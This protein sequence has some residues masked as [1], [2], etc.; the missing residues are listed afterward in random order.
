MTTQMKLLNGLSE[1]S[2]SDLFIVDN[3]DDE[4]KV[5]RY[6]HDWCQL[7]KGFDIASGYFEIASLLA[8]DGEW[9][10]VDH[11]RLLMGNEVSWRT[12]RAFEKA[13]QVLHQRLDDSIETEKEKN[14]FLSGVPAI[15]EAL[16]A[17]KIECR[18]YRKD[19][20]HAKAYLTHGRVDVVGS[21]ALVGSSNFT[22]PGLTEN[23][24]L[25]VQI[26]GTPVAALQKWY[27]RHWEEAEDVTPEILR[28]VERHTQKFLPFE[29]YA[30]SLQELFHGYEESET[31][32][33]RTKSKVY[34]VLA[35]YQKEG[36]HALLK[37]ANKYGGAFLCDG[38]G[39][40][41]T[42]IGMMLIERLVIYERKRVLLLI[43]KAANEPVWQKE[44][45][46]YLPELLEG[47]F[48]SFQMYNHT[49][50]S[51]DKMRD[52][53][54]R[55]QIQADVIIIDEAHHFRNTG[56]Q[57]DEETW[58]E[59][60][61]YW[62]LFDVAGE[63]QVFHL[64]ATPINNSLLDFQH[65]IEL[66]S[67]RRSDYF[68]AAPLGIHSLAGHIRT[69]E[70][71]LEKV[72]RERSEDD[73]TS[74]LNL[75]EAADVL[76]TDALFRELVVQRSRK[77]VK[78]STETAEDDK[79]LFP[80][81]RKPKVAHYSVKQ[82]Y[83]KLLDMV[84]AAFS[85]QE[86]LFKLSIYYPYAF[87]TG[88]DPEVIPAFERGRRMQ[89]VSLVRTGF[90]KRFE[91]SAEAF[92]ASCWNLMR[93][94]LVWVEVHAETEL[95]RDRVEQWKR[96]NA[97]LINYKPQ[98]ELWSDDEDED[99]VSPE[100]LE[101]VDELSRDEFDLEKIILNTF[102]DLDQIAMFLKELEAFTPKQ[103][104]KLQALIK[105]L[106]TD[107]VLKKHKVL[108]FTEY[109]TTARYLKEQLD[110]AGLKGVAEIDSATKVNRFDLIRR[111]APYYNGSSSGA[112][113][114]QGKEEI[115]VLISTD[116]LAEGLN[117]QDA[118]RLINYEL[119]WNPV[120]LMQRIGRVDRRLNPDI[121]QKIIAAHPEQS[122]LR[123]TV[124][125][126][127]FLPPDELDELLRL[128]RRVAHKTLRISKTLGIEGKRLLREDDDY[129]DLRNFTEQYEG[130]LTPI[131]EMHLEYQQ[132]LKDHS[133][134]E[135]RLNGFPKKIF[136]GKENLEPG[137]QQVFFCVARPGHDPEKSK[138]TGE[139]EWTTEAGD[140]Q[141]YL[142]DLSSEQ[143]LEDPAQIIA[144]IHSR[145]DTPRKTVIE[146][147]TLSEIRA[148]IE[149]HIKNSYLKKVQAP[150][151][152]KP[153]IKAWMELN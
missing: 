150:V 56:T 149:K 17:G 82:T 42:F 102:E 141:W 89:V 130:R 87:Y 28:V 122:E 105:L 46:T 16:R 97:E 124:A 67:R 24:E 101:T 43:P 120:K 71:A 60:S 39:L 27:E 57:G 11:I 104:K 64:T 86:P 129:E 84:S 7:A 83:G 134:L 91:S 45:E 33:E 146:K 131:E 36:Y 152:V 139:D 109:L 51:R 59:R 61:R 117:L 26:T 35:R 8:L 58:E 78:R 65:M 10:K 37:R 151:G 73:D 75:V 31:K 74:D 93:K 21:F 114:D 121:E 88:D 106:K 54:K 5:L 76:A 115:R 81:P 118:T 44:L 41:K 140:V 2:G 103:D 98:Y 30:K 62:R 147:A 126:W 22:Y 13:F 110:A 132:L 55:V 79:I 143:I 4:W 125:Y 133:D 47:G 68:G 19:K 119:H 116:V 29:V 1:S 138:K 112:L 145:P 38:V 107:R 9:Q 77:Y 148:K 135:E 100:M 25:N 52:V 49:D 53:F 18:V 40:G 34:P 153:V 14:D 95:E 142:Y 48:Y 108:I 6:L 94:L 3:S 80:K 92:R 111:F 32:W 15:V 63:K 85:K 96:T 128:Y 20:F 70:K 23:V 12:K 113:V 69:L 50:L 136:S 123:G 99:L 72:A 66:F 127:N 144:H 137:T 90:L